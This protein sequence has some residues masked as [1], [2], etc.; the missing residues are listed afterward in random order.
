MIS[1]TTIMMVCDSRRT[2]KLDSRKLLVLQV[3]LSYYFIAAGATA[4]HGREASSESI[5]SRT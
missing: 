3:R 4:G 5:T 2:V 1:M